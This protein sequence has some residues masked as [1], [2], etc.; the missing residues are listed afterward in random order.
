VNNLNTLPYANIPYGNINSIGKQWIRRYALALSKET[1][2]Q[3]R[4]KLNTIPIP[5]SNVTLN[6]SDLLSQAKD[7]KTSLREE[8]NKILD[9]LTYV[10]LAERD[11]ALAETTEKL[12]T[13]I[14][15]PIFVG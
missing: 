9:E 7:E 6:A 1:L 10:K 15:L 3:I 8:L 13:K 2:G 5:G 14:P 12:N 11:A 4:G